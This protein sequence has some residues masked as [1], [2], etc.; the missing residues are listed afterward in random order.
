VDS[1]R[2]SGKSGSP[3][4]IRPSERPMYMR[5]HRHLA[6]RTNGS[7]LKHCDYESDR[8]SDGD[9]CTRGFTYSDEVVRSGGAIS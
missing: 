9:T 2:G 5:V 1:D 7:L 8:E 3:M 4:E 6:H